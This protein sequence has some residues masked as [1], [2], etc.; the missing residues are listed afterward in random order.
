MLD[1]CIFP[2][3]FLDFGSPGGEYN[4]YWDVDKEDGTMSTGYIEQGLSGEAQNFHRGLA[5]LIEEL[6]AVDWYHQRADVIT[7]QDLKAVLVHNRN[8]EMEHAAMTLEWLRRV[9]PPL[10]QALRR[11][12]F[13]SAPIT[14]IEVENRGSGSSGVGEEN[15]SLGIGALS[16]GGKE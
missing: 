3:L 15:G 4:I 8:E 7:D 6:E 14:R 10:D 9:N 11:F 12:L 13:T 5:S 16:K 1:V 2:H